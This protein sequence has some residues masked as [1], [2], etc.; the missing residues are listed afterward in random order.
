MTSAFLSSPFLDSVH[1]KL[2]APA[3]NVSGKCSGSA[4]YSAGNLAKAM[5][6]VAIE[7]ASNNSGG[8]QE[9]VA[10]SQEQPFGFMQLGVL[11]SQPERAGTY[12]QGASGSMQFGIRGN[13]VPHRLMLELSQTHS[14]ELPPLW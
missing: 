2:A 12:N 3:A 7:D 10:M 9:G 6:L 8:A 14:Q 13:V 1:A 11:T 5:S 4:P